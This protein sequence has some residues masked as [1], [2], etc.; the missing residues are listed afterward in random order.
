MTWYQTAAEV[1]LAMDV[2]GADTGGADRALAVLAAREQMPR[3]QPGLVVSCGTA[4][5]IERLTAGGVWQGGVIAP[6]LFLG[7]P[8]L[9]PADGSVAS[10]PSRPV[11]PVLG[12]WDPG[13]AGGRHLLGRRRSCPGA[14][15]SPDLRAGRDA[16]D[17]LD[18]R[19]R[20]ATGPPG[21]WRQGPDSP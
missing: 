5:T 3:G 18:R 2:E 1:P 15:G 11:G 17:R 13:L 8:R 6:G 12:S 21:L 14:S 4:I 16:L 9:A 10:D 7:A 19:R 20:R